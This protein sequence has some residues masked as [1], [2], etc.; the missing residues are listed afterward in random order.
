MTV[1]TAVARF[2]RRQADLFR[3]TG[4]LSRPAG[5]GTLN[6]STGDYVAASATVVYSGPCLIRA[7]TWEGT[8]VDFGDIEVRLRRARV[9]FPADTDLR[10][11]D[12]FVASAS[13]F[14]ESLVG[15]SFRCTDAFR[16]GWQIARVG[17][18]EE[19]TGG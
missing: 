16:D 17:I 18:F 15:V 7:F 4:T 5:S 19:I 2:R 11:D 8:D 1:D 13:T 3:D 6:T 14:D 12:I 10:K 9:K